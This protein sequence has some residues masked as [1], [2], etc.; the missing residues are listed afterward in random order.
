MALDH[1]ASTAKKKKKA[2]EQLTLPVRDRPD[3]S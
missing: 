3:L 2:K 1:A